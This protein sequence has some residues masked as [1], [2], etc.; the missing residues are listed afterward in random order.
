MTPEQLDEYLVSFGEQVSMRSKNG[1]KMIP[2]VKLR[3]Y[4]K[5]AIE[6]SEQRI[7]CEFHNQASKEA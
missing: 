6:T 5:K 2:A 3:E 7:R 4:I 1:G